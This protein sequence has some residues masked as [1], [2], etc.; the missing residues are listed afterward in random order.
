MTLIRVQMRTL[1]RWAIIRHH[2]FSLKLLVLIIFVDSLLF[3]SM[4][5]NAMRSCRLPLLLR[6]LSNWLM[7]P[8]RCRDC[9]RLTLVHSRPF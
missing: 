1:W 6:V 3:N 2:I 9:R 7:I 8:L 5:S 4:L